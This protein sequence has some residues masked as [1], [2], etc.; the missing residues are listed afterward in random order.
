MEKQASIFVAGGRT[1]I[2]AAIHRALRWEGY[3]GIVAEP[4]AGPDLRC[5][6]AVANFFARTRPRY[7]FLVAGMSGGIG[8][9]RTY[10]ASLML[11]N[12]TVQNHVIESAYRFGAARLFYLASSCSYPR[13][14]PQ[15]MREESLF[16]GPLEPTNE[17][18]AV[19]KLAGLTLCKAYH[20]Q[21]GADF[22]SAI[23][24]NVFGP[25]DDFSPENSHVIG[26]LM[27]RMHTAKLHS[28]PCVPIW[29]TG[30]ARR[31]FI[32]VDDIAAA[33]LFL[34]NTPPE[35]VGIG[36]INIG[37][38]ETVSIRELAEAIQAVVG[39]TGTLA[40]CTEKP[41]G[42]PV[43]QL[44]ASRIQALGWRPATSLRT[45][46]EATYSAYLKTL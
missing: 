6:S 23:P 10:P 8:A 7:V 31:E 16:T 38:G 14:C 1:L 18:Y 41:D 34:M 11:D 28:E 39:Y 25:G 5:A 42:M 37:G 27:A 45:G 21:Y 24:A 40:Y 2:G 4:E 22:V 46:L 17:A 20:D 29:G 15:P 43:K 32:Y 44:D 36:P 13:D 12:L 9:N 33:C 26:A 35:Q 19:A 30:I 3:T